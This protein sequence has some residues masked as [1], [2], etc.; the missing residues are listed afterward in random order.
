[1]WKDQERKPR[2]EIGDPRSEIRDPE[3]GDPEIGPGRSEIEIFIF[4]KITQNSKA[5]LSQSRGNS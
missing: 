5:L 3:I 1:M 2:S 4:L